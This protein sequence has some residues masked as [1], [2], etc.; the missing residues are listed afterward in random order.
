MEISPIT[1]V[2]IAPMVRPREADLGLTDVC[3]V[4]RSSRTGDETYSPRVAKA[5][6]GFEDDDDTFD[7]LDDDLDGESKP[8]ST[9]HGKIS[10]FA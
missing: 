9:R 4:G 3:E 7:E 6:S 10:R 8:L 5:A 1:G 2:R